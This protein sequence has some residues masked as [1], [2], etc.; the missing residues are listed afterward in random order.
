MPSGCCRIVAAAVLAAIVVLAVVVVGDV[1]DARRGDPVA[2]VADDENERRVV[3]A[4][5][6]AML[7]RVHAVHTRR[8]AD[9]KAGDDFRYRA[10]DCGPRVAA[11]EV[12]DNGGEVRRKEVRRIQR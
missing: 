12:R 10:A 2:T 8:A 11:A 6:T 7:L 5:S 9:L 1:H 4:V 3:V